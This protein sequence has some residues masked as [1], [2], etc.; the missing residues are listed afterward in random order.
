MFMKCICWG[1]TSC[2]IPP[3]DSARKEVSLKF[4]TSVNLLI[5]LAAWPI[6]SIGQAF[7]AEK[8]LADSH[9]YE[10]K[11]GVFSSGDG[12]NLPIRPP[13]A[14][15]LEE[16]V[17]KLGH[18]R[19]ARPDEPLLI[20]SLAHPGNEGLLAAINSVKNGYTTGCAWTAVL[21]VY[22]S[23]S[24]EERATFLRRI[25][26]VNIRLG[27][28]TAGDE[29]ERF[30]TLYGQAMS[31][32]DPRCYLSPEGL[33]ADSGLGACCGEWLV[34][35]GPKEFAGMSFSEGVVVRSLEFWRNGLAEAFKSDGWREKERPDC[36]FEATSKY[37]DR[38]RNE[39]HD[40]S[41]PKKWQLSFV[42][43]GKS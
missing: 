39:G 14:R 13:T 25:E 28:K 7:A 32:F 40:L 15:A 21:V 17:K 6:L 36:D 16:T 18:M 12:F 20:T 11:D 27:P 19:M 4:K 23:L 26:T 41:D 9:P 34:P 2:E 42:R 31:D 29:V 8:E 35:V 43:D 30:H 1:P 24:Y 33:L 10:S 37:L 22:M 5:I 38:L 3:G